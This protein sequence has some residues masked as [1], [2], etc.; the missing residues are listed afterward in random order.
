MLRP[1][2]AFHESVV[3]D[4]ALG[5]FRDLG[6]ETEFGPDLAPDGKTPEREN[7]NDVVLVERLKAAI[8]RLNPHLSADAREDAYRKVLRS[9]SPSVVVSNRRFH[10]VFAN[11]IDVETRKKE[12]RIAGDKAWL[13]DFKH[14][15]NNDW[16]VS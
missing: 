1:L 14:P 4:A 6:Y 15:E 12:G 11:G 13:V 5:Y 10:E 7:W 2:L 8:D 9:E 3:E 16:L